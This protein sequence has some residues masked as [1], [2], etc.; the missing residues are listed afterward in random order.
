ME[1]WKTQELEALAKNQRPLAPW[2]LADLGISLAEAIEA[3]P[4]LK[5]AWTYQGL[6]D[7]STGHACQCPTCKGVGFHYVYDNPDTINPG[8]PVF[9]EDCKASGFR[10]ETVPGLMAEFEAFNV[11]RR[12]QYGFCTSNS[13]SGFALWLGHQHPDLHRYAREIWESVSHVGL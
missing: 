6:P 1:Y 11:A 3:V 4:S 13:V 10:A 7:H 5:D 2:I 12:Q 9:C 8:R